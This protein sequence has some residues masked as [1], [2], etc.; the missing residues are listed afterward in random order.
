M[1]HR[2]VPL[3]AAVV[4]AALGL[5]LPAQERRT[6]PD[7]ARIEAD[8]AEFILPAHPALRS[9]RGPEKLAKLAET[10]LAEALPEASANGSLHYSILDTALATADDDRAPVKAVMGRDVPDDGDQ[11]HANCQKRAKA[12]CEPDQRPAA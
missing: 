8:V 2:P 6:P 4:I 3:L 11:R 1:E 7:R 5:C 12:G 10:L 9:A